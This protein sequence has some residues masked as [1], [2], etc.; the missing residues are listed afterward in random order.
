MTFLVFLISLLVLERIVRGLEIKEIS[1]PETP[2]DTSAGREKSAGTPAQTASLA[3][4]G[5]ALDQYGRGQ[6]PGA[7]GEPVST[8]APPGR[9]SP[10]G[11]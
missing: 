6:A 5:Q 11:R 7:A 1:P 4:L 3:T 2:T 8:V 9:V 10:K